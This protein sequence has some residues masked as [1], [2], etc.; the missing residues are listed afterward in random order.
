MTRR[1]DSISPTAHYTGFA[2]FRH[3]LSHPALVTPQGRMLHGALRPMHVAADMVGAPTL[4]A[5]LLARHRIIDHLLDQAIEEGRV[6]QIIELAAGLSPRGWRFKQ[7]HGARIRYI[8][9]DLPDMA[10]RKATLLQTAGLL[11][12]G[13]EVVSLDALSNSGPQSLAALADTLDANKGLAIVTEGLINYFDTHTVLGMWQRFAKVLAR[14][15]HGLYLSDIHLSDVRQK[16]AGVSAF[17]AVLSA[18]VKGRV[19][20]HFDNSV[21]A[22]TAL[23]DAGFAFADLHHPREFAIKLG[24][25]MRPGSGLV[26]VIEARSSKPQ[27]EL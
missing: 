24:L 19:F 14:F 1:T 6:E 9:A 23:H 12:P 20:L 11:T 3:G 18:F 26:R 5:F 27:V 15:P 25:D 4:S 7:R 21:V 17:M 16:S 8:E 10:Q 22:T 13:H 2:W